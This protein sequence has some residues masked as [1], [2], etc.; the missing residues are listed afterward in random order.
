MAVK[1][2]EWRCA[3]ILVV[4][5]HTLRGFPVV[6]VEI[7]KW[8]DYTEAVVRD[9]RGKRCVCSPILLGRKASAAAVKRARKRRLAIRV[10][11]AQAIIHKAIAEDGECFTDQELAEALAGRS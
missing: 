8:P 3:P 7:R 1:V 6:V 10:A 2:G 4:S 11:N 5:N 9:V